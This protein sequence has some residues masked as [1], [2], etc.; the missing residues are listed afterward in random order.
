M[1]KISEAIKMPI[2]YKTAEQATKLV[3]ESNVAITGMLKAIGYK[4]Q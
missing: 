4:K 3:Q 1:I 2:V